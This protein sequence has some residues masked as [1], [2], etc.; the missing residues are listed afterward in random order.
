MRPSYVAPTSTTIDTSLPPISTLTPFTRVAAPTSVSSSTPTSLVPVGNRTLTTTNSTLTPVS[1]FKAISPRETS[2][3]PYE[4][5]QY[6][7]TNTG[8]KQ[9]FKFDVNSISKQNT[10]LGLEQLGKSAEFK[11]WANSNPK[12]ARKLIAGLRSKFTNA[13]YKNASTAKKDAYFNKRVNEMKSQ[14]G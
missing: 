5:I 6:K 4:Q 13:R 14:F 1:T 11:E 7:S 10:L 8:N 12:E 9:F 3:A 2:V